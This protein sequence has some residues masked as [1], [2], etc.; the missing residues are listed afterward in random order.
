[1]LSKFLLPDSIF[2]EE[3]LQ[4]ERFSDVKRDENRA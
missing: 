4:I 1:M 3:F 2:L